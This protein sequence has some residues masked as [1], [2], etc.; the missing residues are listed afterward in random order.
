LSFE[1]YGE[2][3]VE[4][5]LGARPKEIHGSGMGRKRPKRM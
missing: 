1:G 4:E 5:K 2:Y 3:S